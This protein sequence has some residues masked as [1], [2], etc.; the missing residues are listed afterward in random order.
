MLESILRGEGRSVGT[1]EKER[2]RH[3]HMLGCVTEGVKINV[4]R[5]E[6]FHS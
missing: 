2:E 3:V 4:V 6:L 1:T 5:A